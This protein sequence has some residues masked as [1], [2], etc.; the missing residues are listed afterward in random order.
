[1]RLSKLIELIN[2]FNKSVVKKYYITNQNNTNM[3]YQKVSMP[4]LLQLNASESNPVN[5]LSGSDSVKELVLY[6]LLL[7]DVKI[8]NISITH[9]YLVLQWHPDNNRKNIQ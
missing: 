5:I 6:P 9:P 3:E 7:E 2:S 4:Y 8:K 1:M